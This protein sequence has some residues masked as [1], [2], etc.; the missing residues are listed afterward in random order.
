MTD[1]DDKQETNQVIQFISFVIL[2]LSIIICV[3]ADIDEIKQYGLDLEYNVIVT[4]LW[5]TA[6]LSL[7]TF[8]VAIVLCCDCNFK[9]CLV[10]IYSLATLVGCIVIIYSYGELWY[11]HLEEYMLY[12]FDTFF[13][14]LRSSS[15]PDSNKKWVYTMMVVIVKI[16]TGCFILSLSLIAVCAILWCCGGLCIMK[17][18]KPANPPTDLTDTLTTIGFE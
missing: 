4:N 9:A 11:A 15:I 7:L 17:S 10:T 12:Y 13:G 6:T 8:F 1:E 18:H 5:V 2:V 3:N 14:S 16:E